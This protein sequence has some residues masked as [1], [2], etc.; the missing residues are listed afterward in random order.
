M[1]DRQAVHMARLID[2]LLGVSRIAHGKVLLRKEVL[3][4]VKVVGATAQDYRSG[5]EAAGLTL[6]LQLPEEPLWVTGDPTRL[7][8]IVGNVL[9]N[10]SKFTDPGGTS[11]A[12]GGATA[13]CRA[14]IAAGYQ[15]QARSSR[16]VPGC[17]AS[18]KC[19]S[20]GYP[21]RLPS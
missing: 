7:A 20:G 19:P 6:K 15:V 8:Q 3:D 13:V 5:L 11:A 16:L 14:V 4:L 1:I 10:A 12:V 2:D 21:D 17:G 9:H 18:A